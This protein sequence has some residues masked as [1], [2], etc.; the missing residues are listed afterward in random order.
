[1][2]ITFAGEHKERVTRLVHLLDPREYNSI[3]STLIKKHELDHRQFTKLIAHQVYNHIR[4]FLIRTDWMKAE[5][6]CNF[7]KDNLSVLAEIMIMK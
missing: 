1:M 3:A 4:S 5:E 6:I 7:K 2:A